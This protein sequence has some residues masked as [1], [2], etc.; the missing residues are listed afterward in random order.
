MKKKFLITALIPHNTLLFALQKEQKKL[1][2]ALHLTPVYPLLCPLKII[3]EHTDFVAILAEYRKIFQQDAPVLCLNPP[4]FLQTEQQQRILVRSVSFENC[5]IVKEQTICKDFFIQHT[6]SFL[7][8]M[9][10]FQQTAHT[11][12]EEALSAFSE[13][14]L[15][16]FRLAVISF[17]IEANGNEETAPKNKSVFW[18]EEQSI[19]I[20][21]RHL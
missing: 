8:G 15:S 7:Y 14:Q 13:A 11:G 20:N 2:S 19:W 12:K 3:G 17:L 4:H 6:G 5:S 21:T 10:I 1:C 18:T 16:V 9:D